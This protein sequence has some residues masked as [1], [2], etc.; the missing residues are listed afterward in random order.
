MRIVHALGWYFPE[1]LGGTEVYVDGLARR[2]QASGHD[3]QVAAP[4]AGGQGL[5]QGAHAGVPVLRYPI[6]LRPTTPMRSNF[7]KT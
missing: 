4:R 3:V 6:P 7:L 1:S 2:L 5:E